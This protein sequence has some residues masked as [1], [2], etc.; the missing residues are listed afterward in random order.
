MDLNHLA[1]FQAVAETQ[2]FTKAAGRLG[3]DKSRVSRALRA[4]E[5]SLGT[6][7]LART[8]RTVRLTAEG[9]ALLRQV[10]PLLSGLRAA[11]A[12]APDKPALPTGEVTLTAPPEV[13]RALLAPVL[14]RFRVRHPLVRVRAVLTYEVVDLLEKGVD[15]ALRVGRPGAGTFVARKLMDLE[16]GFFASPRYLERRSEPSTLADLERHEC[17]WPPP[18]RGRGPFGVGR[19]RPPPAASVECSDFGFLAELARSGGGIALL[20]TFVA[21]QD[22]ALGSLVRVLPGIAFRDAPLFLVSRPGTTVPP[23]VQVFKDF[24]RETLGR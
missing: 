9:E 3:L 15:L 17:L 16:A 23:R 4:L 12:G 18:P 13:G 8:T 10:A 24:L 11:M 7:L 20:P 6:T 14:A 1:V 21:A 2:S 19:G 22:V 5:D